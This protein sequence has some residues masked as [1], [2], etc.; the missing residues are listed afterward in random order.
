MQN[1]RDE[2]SDNIKDSKTFKFKS[3]FI[4]KSDDSGTVNVKIVVLLQC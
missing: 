2:P 1:Y 3:G 4:D